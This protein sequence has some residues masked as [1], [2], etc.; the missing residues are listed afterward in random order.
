MVV[1][2]FNLNIVP[3]NQA[4]VISDPQNKK[5]IAMNGGFPLWTIY[6]VQPSQLAVSSLLRARCSW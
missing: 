5:F 6:T 3:H 1:G 2:L 4:A